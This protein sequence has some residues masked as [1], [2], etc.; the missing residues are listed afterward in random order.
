MIGIKLQEISTIIVQPWQQPVIVEPKVIFLVPTMNTEVSAYNSGIMGPL[1]ASRG[2]TLVSSSSSSVFPSDAKTASSRLLHSALQST[3]EVK[4]KDRD[5]FSAGSRDNNAGTVKG[6]HSNSRGKNNHKR[7]NQ[8]LVFDDGSLSSKLP[9]HVKYVDNTSTVVAGNEQQ[10]AVGTVE[11]FEKMNKVAKLSGFKNAQEMLASQKEMLMLMQKSQ[12]PALQQA[13][14]TVQP[15]TSSANQHKQYPFSLH[16]TPWGG[17]GRAGRGRSF[18]RATQSIL[19]SPTQGNATESAD[20]IQRSWWSDGGRWV[21]G[22]AGRGG[23]AFPLPTQ[24][25]EA[26]SGGER[27]IS[28]LEGG[29]TTAVPSPLNTAMDLSESAA[30]GKSGDHYYHHRHK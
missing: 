5:S 18:G 10:P 11:Y 26:T 3:R 22:R 21:D 17:G 1:K 20:S 8:E 30:V 14:S 15:E 7:G 23:R 24:T 19:H 2:G 6:L 25:Q 29:I 13:P 12:T 9:K 4:N 27:A 28:N 16:P